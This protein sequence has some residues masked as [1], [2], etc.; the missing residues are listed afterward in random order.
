MRVVRT[1]MLG[2][3]VLGPLF[4]G[5]AA[6]ASGA[7]FDCLIEPRQVLELRAPIEGLIDRVNVDRGDYVRKGQ[8]LVV[9]DTR[10]DQVQAAISSHRA[11]MEGALRSWESKGELSAKKSSR[12]DQLHG[13]NFISAQMRDEATTEKRIAE[14]E[15]RDAVDTR[16]L[17]G[18]EHQRQL[19]VIRLKTIR[20]PVNGVVIERF[21]N[22]GE[23]AE[24]GV[25][26]KPLLKIAEIDTLH[27]EVLLPAS[28]FGKVKLGSEIE[29]APEIPAGSSHRAKVKVIDR[30]LDAA[31]G[32]FG[33]RLELPNPQ[34]KIL[35][36]IRC[37]ANFPEID[38][39][40]VAK[41]RGQARA[42][43]P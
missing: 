11:Q 34:R 16:K 43:R 41:G 13:Q 7:E 35:G 3:M 18:L 26:R 37:R 28:A 8:D 33:V 42:P 15:L 14:A 30:V 22:P 31:S 2:L 23:F 4:A 19:E 39:A 12:M 24:A 1:E 20:S 29:V 6:S 10:V 17:A 5:A 36:G 25:G 9:L 40:L 32:T 27:V 21:L 38:A